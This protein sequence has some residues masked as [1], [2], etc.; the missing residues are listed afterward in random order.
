MRVELCVVRH[1]GRTEMI[2]SVAIL[3]GIIPAL[4]TALSADEPAKVESGLALSSGQKEFL[5]LEP[6]LVTL[7]TICDHIDDF[8]GVGELLG[9]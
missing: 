1:A 8:K 9:D 3:L 7:K 5:A 6:I 2:R 4:S